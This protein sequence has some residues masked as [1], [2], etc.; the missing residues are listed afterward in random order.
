M[1]LDFEGSIHVIFGPMFSGKSTE[2]LRRMR[3]YS[4][5]K[6]RCLVLKYKRDVRYADVEMLAT[7]D[8]VTM[9]A[10]PCI[11]LHEAIEEVKDYDVVGVDEGQFFPD[12]VEFCETCA[13]MGKIVIVAALDGTFQRKAFNTILNLVP[14]AESVT[15]LKSICSV[16]TKEAAFSKRIVSGDE[17]EVIGGSDTYMAVCRHCY[18]LHHDAHEKVTKKAISIIER[19]RSPASFIP[20]DSL[21]VAPINQGIKANHRGRDI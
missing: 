1:E 13:N 3:R 8:K 7:H 16:C 2:L 4:I 9:V 20:I 18:H 10:R 17:V 5:A 6:R 19:N 21:S 15:K 11:E 14:L 12:V